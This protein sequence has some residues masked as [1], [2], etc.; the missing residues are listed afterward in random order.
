[1]RSGLGIL[2]KS[3]GLE[4]FQELAQVLLTKGIRLVIQHFQEHD[5]EFL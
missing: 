4:P 5:V 1:M 3:F 2:R